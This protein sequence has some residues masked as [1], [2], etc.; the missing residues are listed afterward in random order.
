MYMME[1]ALIKC[2]H[3]FGTV[4]TGKDIIDH[5][6]HYISTEMNA[7]L[8]VHSLLSQHLLNKDEVKNLM[9]AASGYQKNILLVEKIR[10]MDIEKLKTF[11]KLLQSLDSHK[12]ISDVLVHGKLTLLHIVN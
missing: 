2:V 7:D 5:Y 3:I 11:F 1:K 12:H 8:I 4:D 6:Y 9:N 10:L